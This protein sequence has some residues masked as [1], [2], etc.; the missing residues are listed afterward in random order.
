M[1]GKVK[2]KWPFGRVLAELRKSRGMSGEDL[3]RASG[4][5]YSTLVNLEIGRAGDISVGNLVALA[6]ALGVKTARIDPR[7]D[8]ESAGRINDA[9]DALEAA[10]LAFAA[11]VSN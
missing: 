1:A 11:A 9:M 8:P 5:N 7:I 10:K 6:A 3:A 2:A 4:I